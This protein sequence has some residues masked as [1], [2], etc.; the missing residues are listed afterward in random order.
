MNEQEHSGFLALLGARL[1]SDGCGPITLLGSAPAIGRIVP[2]PC[3]P[4]GSFLDPALVF[5]RRALGPGPV[6]TRSV[7][8][9]GWCAWVRRK[10]CACGRKLWRD[11]CPSFRYGSSMHREANHGALSVRGHHVCGAFLGARS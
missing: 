1:Q 3:F 10:Q 5:S 6:T 9:V 7:E 8:A 11:H 4:V 2:L